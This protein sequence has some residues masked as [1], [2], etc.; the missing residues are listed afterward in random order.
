MYKVR[1]NT[2]QRS[3]PPEVA[4]RVSLQN[5]STLGWDRYVGRRGTIIGMRRPRSQ[6]HDEPNQFAR[7]Q[8]GTAVVTCQRGHGV[9]DGPALPGLS[10]N[11]AHHHQRRVSPTGL[12]AACKSMVFFKHRSA[13]DKRYS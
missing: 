12:S 3:A 4:A 10:A 11:T 7:R 1:L 6:H 5:A 13:A 2:R 8:G 9:L